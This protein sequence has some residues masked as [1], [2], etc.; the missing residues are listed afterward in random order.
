MSSFS[1]LKIY[2]TV[3]YIGNLESEGNKTAKRERER[4]RACVSV[5]VWGGG[6]SFHAASDVLGL[7]IST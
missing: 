1:M 6:D 7:A 3:L 5:R 2:L 4:V